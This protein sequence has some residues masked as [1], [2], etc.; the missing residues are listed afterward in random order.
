MPEVLIPTARG[1]MPAYLAVPAGEGPKPGVIVLHDIGGMTRD[2]RNQAGWLAE[3]GFLTLAV[4]LYYRGGVLLCLRSVIRDLT[5]RSGPAF[6]DVESC[7]AWLAA[8][9]NC[10]GRVGVIGFCMGGGFALLL[11]SGHG[12][13]AAS[14]N[15]GGP[16]PRD[17]DD[18]LRTACPVVGSYGG[19]A[20]WEQGV[21]EEL[22][23][24][25]DRALIANDVLEYPEAGHSFMNNHQYFFFKV[26][27]WAVLRRHGIG[28]HEPS[29]MDARRRII[30]FFHLH[31][32]SKSGFSV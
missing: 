31:L 15:Y 6:D 28:Y 29:C 18:F 30:A 21:A 26:L 9:P 4:D 12:F 32:E 14:I 24:K 2:H 11:V 25:L 23:R 10:T 3:A 7:R 13:S 20:K 22:R 17:I 8:Q 27:R 16:L 5:N 19:L 1:T